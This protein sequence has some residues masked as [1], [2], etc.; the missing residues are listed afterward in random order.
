MTVDDEINAY[1]VFETLNA[2]GLSLSATDLLKNYLFTILHNSKKVDKTNFKIL[3]D[4][5]SKIVARIQ[6]NKVLDF[7]R[8]HWNSRNPLVRKLELYKTIKRNINDPKAVFE[9]ISKMESDIDDY[10]ALGR[11]RQVILGAK[12]KKT[13]RQS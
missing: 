11:S 8:I 6:D 10:L 4:R 12:R 9:F 1:I 3:E 5:W 7:V 2:R 13:M